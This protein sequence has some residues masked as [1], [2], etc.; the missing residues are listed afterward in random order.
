MRPS[1][2]FDE[3]SND[4]CIYVYISDQDFSCTRSGQPEVVQEVLENLKNL[5]E[6]AA[7]RAVEA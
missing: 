6:R 7:E 1:G 2:W 3:S 4:S 5:F